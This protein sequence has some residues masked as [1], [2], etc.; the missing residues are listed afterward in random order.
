MDEIAILGLILL[1]ALLIYGFY[2][3]HEEL[4]ICESK[5]MSLG[6]IGDGAFIPQGYVRCAYV[7]NETVFYKIIPRR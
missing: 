1:I 2:D 5:G 7:A 3:M 4:K 6:P